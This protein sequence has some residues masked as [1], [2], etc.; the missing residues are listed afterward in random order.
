[1]LTFEPVSASC[2]PAC[3]PKHKGISSFDGGS[4]SR[5]AATTTTGRSA[6]TAALTVT[7]AVRAATDEHHQHDEPRAA[8]ARSIDELLPGPRRDAGGVER[9][10]DHEQRRD[11]DHDRV[12]EPGERLLEGQDA[13]RPQRQRGAERHDLDRHAAP[14]EEDDDRRDDR[15]GDRDVAHAAGSGLDGISRSER[16]TE[17]EPDH[18]ER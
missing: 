6:A 18:E 4:E 17:H 7:T 11:E 1:M 3:A 14:D 16:Q 15:E 12:A 13:G 5:L 10:A 2:E 8:R 9:L